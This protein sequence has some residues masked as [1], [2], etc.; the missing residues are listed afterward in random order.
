MIRH[1]NTVAALALVMAGSA[2]ATP[3]NPVGFG[4]VSQGFLVPGAVYHGAGQT[5]AVG[6]TNRCPPLRVYW[7]FTDA[8][9][10]FVVGGSIPIDAAETYPFILA[11]ETVGHGAG[12]YGTLMFAADSNGDG[13]LTSADDHCLIAEAFQADIGNNDAAF[14]PVWPFNTW[15]LGAGN[16]IPDLYMMMPTQL[17]TLHSG[18][19]D[20]PGIT[21]KDVYIR[22]SIGGGDTTR[23]VF[24][25]AE[26][27]TL[28]SSPVLVTNHDGDAEM[29][30]LAL[31]NDHLNVID[32]GS[33]PGF[34]AGFTNG[35]IA[36]VLADDGVGDYTDAHGD[37]NGVAVYGT[38]HSPGLGATQTILGSSTP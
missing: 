34:P 14:I 2:S 15:D 1:A 30:T 31:P 23:I 27:A 28:S 16:S 37:G 24:W 32:V 5:T 3:Y 17:T 6:L 25:S 38:I 20:P 26:S 10:D 11:T 4:N 9:D 13:A 22:Y 29:A 7:T 35:I 8:D 33:L 19:M 21:D 18:I 12:K 36:A